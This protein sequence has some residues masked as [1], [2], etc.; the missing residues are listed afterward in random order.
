MSTLATELTSLL[1]ADTV[2]GY[3][4]TP[5]QVNGVNISAVIECQSTTRGFVLPRMTTAEK[6]AIAVKID[7]MEVF[8]TTLGVADIYKNGAWQGGFG[9]GNVVGPANSPNNGVA[10]F[11]GVTGKLI[12]AAAVAINPI[13]AVVTGIASLFSSSGTAGAPTYSFTGDTNTGVYSDQADSIGIATAGVLQFR[14]AG[15]SNAVNDVLIAGTSSSG[16]GNGPTISAEGASSTIAI[17]VLGKGSGNLLTNNRYAFS[18][19]TSSGM[20]YNSGS[21]YLSFDLSGASKVTV[22]SRGLNVGTTAIESTGLTVLTIGTNGTNTPTG[23]ANSLQIYAP[24]LGGNA[25][26][27]G[28]TMNAAAVTDSIVNANQKKIRIQINGTSYYL[29]AST[30]AT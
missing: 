6:N 2:N 28:L 24:T 8:D 16:T 5:T 13:S 19:G 9:N 29:L 22:N 27:L 14:V 21:L 10:V 26:C 20:S 12:Q 18:S 4:A 3:P 30:D 25:G 7:G 15:P 1:A 17:S 23:V 11:N